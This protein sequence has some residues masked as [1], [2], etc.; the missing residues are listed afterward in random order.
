MDTKKPHIDP[1][2]LRTR[3]LLRNAFVELLQEMDM[4]K[5]SVNRLTKQATINRVTFYL[6][7]RDIPDMLEKM[8]DEMIEDISM[9]FHTTIENEKSTEDKDLQLLVHLFEHIAGQADFYKTILTKRVPVFRDRLLQFLKDS[10]VTRLEQV[11]SD[12]Y[13]RKSGVQK[14]ILIWYISSALIGTIV[15]WL[16]K[17]MPYTPTYLAKQFMLLHHRGE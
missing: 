6:H 10:V 15:I 11:R 16:Q 9:V 3:Q 5:I 14:D 13:V 4:E 17:D 12:S 7:Y 1:R 8:A 2:I